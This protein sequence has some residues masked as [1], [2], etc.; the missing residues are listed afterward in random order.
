MMAECKICQ[1]PLLETE[2][3]QKLGERGA[4]NINEKSEL[5]RS[6][7]RVEKGDVV[8]VKCQQNW[9][10]KERVAAAIKNLVTD[11]LTADSTRLRSSTPTF[12]FKSQC[13]Y[14]GH[15]INV[16]R[17]K[18]KSQDVFPVRTLSFHSALIAVCNKREDKWG[19]EVKQRIV[20]TPDLPAAD[21]IYHKVCDTNFRTLR[22]MPQQYTSGTEQTKKKARLSGRPADEIK[23]ACFLKVAE[24]FEQNDDFFFFNIIIYSWYSYLQVGYIHL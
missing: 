17:S 18:R 12:D 6:S 22:P 15:A 8:H 10:N 7:V 5:R 23:A 14:C 11:E 20:P 24:Y 19:N 1:Q 2:K 9:I 3:T 4:K 16:E 21:A 13:L